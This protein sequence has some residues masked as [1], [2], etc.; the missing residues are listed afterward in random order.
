MAEATDDQI[1]QAFEYA[2]VALQK[3]RRLQA[4]IAYSM[5]YNQEVLGLD[6]MTARPARHLVGVTTADMVTDNIEF[7]TSLAMDEN[8]DCPLPIL[9]R[10]VELIDQAEALMII[11]PLAGDMAGRMKTVIMLSSLDPDNAI[12]TY[13]GAE[14]AMFEMVTYAVW[15]LFAAGD[16]VFKSMP[17]P[18][19]YYPE[20]QGEEI[21]APGELIDCSDCSEGSDCLFNDANANNPAVWVC[22]AQEIARERGERQQDYIIEI[23]AEGDGFR[24]VEQWSGCLGEVQRTV[25]VSVHTAEEFHSEMVRLLVGDNGDGDPETEEVELPEW[26]EAFKS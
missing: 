22:L 12:E 24:L 23:E 14:D 6:F 1:R 18:E 5:L 9:A 8:K 16:M 20:G 25:I 15:D 3:W 4:D 17:E 10:F 13:K 19:F 2:P 21:D 11:P 7:L 26:L